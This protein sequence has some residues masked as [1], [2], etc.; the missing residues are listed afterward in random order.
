MYIPFIDLVRYRIAGHMR[1]IRSR[2]TSQTSVNSA[3]TEI[4][5]WCFYLLR[6]TAMLHGYHHPLR[7]AMIG[8]LAYHLRTVP[9]RV[10]QTF[11]QHRSPET[12]LIH[13]MGILKEREQLRT[14][15][16]YTVA[17]FLSR[18]FNQLAQ[19]PALTNF[20]GTLST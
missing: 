13:F 2:I 19:Q 15:E 18:S 12:V 7:L 16:N 10:V 3:T 9:P 6:P 20:T 17:L 11:L 5:R 8:R 14:E 4:A 1:V